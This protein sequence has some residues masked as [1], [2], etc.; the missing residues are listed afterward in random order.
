MKK[1]EQLY[2]G[3]AKKVFT[4]DNPDVLIV[5][6]KDDATAFNGE[7]KGT[8]VGKGVMNEECENVHI[9]N[10]LDVPV[11]A[12]GMKNVVI[13][14]SPDGI[15][16]SDKEQ[17]SYIK[18]FV[19][20]FEQQTM[21]AEKSW[22]SFRILDIGEGSL[23]VKVTLKPGHSMNYHCHRNRDE[24]W[25]VISGKGRCV[26]DGMEKNIAKGDIVTMKAGCKHTVFADS[27]LKL[28]E[29]QIGNSINVSDKEKFE[30]EK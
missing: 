2:E 5:D 20:C 8:I 7:K 3:K 9:L 30:P 4:T 17:S 22:G 13:T 25:V 24:I 18:P 29:V 16:V 10:E 11:L 15:L 26:L 19:D 27:Q 28:I 6:Y 1:L 21:F 12:M 23:T 14:A